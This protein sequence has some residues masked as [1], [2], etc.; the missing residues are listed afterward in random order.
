LTKLNKSDIIYKN[1]ILIITNIKNA[2][3]N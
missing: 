2:K 3:E 1:L